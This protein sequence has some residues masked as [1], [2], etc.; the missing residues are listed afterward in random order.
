[1]DP[2]TSDQLKAALFDPICRI[3]PA[4]R[5]AEDH[6]HIPGAALT[7]DWRLNSP[8]LLRSGK[9]EG[10]L[11][12][13]NLQ[14][15]LGLSGTRFFP[16]L[17]GAILL[18]ECNTSVPIGEIDRDLAHLKLL[19][20]FAKA[21]GIIFGALGRDNDLSLPALVQKH[22][23]DFEGPVMSGFTSSHVDPMATV[24]IGAPHWMDAD[25]GVIQFQSPFGMP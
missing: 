10:P 15:L 7:R 13:G 11:L 20:A 2:Y 21:K 24:A 12:G 25:K 17:T 8:P 23:G 14:T 9:A 6:W 22:I 1:L 4:D 18:I 5:L 16:D 3:R 19:G